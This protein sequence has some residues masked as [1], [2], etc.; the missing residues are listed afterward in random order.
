MS[1][2]EA[3]LR[4][5][6]VIVVVRLTSSLVAG[7]GCGLGL[8]AGAGAGLARVV[9]ISPIRALVDVTLAATVGY[10]AYQ[11]AYSTTHF[12]LWSSP[13]FGF[14]IIVG[15]PWSLLPAIV[16]FSVFVACSL[17]GF[18]KG[19]SLPPAPA[20]KQPLRLRRT[21]VGSSI[22][23]YRRSVG[24]WMRSEMHAA[25]VLIRSSAF[26]ALA[27]KLSGEETAALIGQSSPVW[28]AAIPVDEALNDMDD[29]T[30]DLGREGT[31]PDTTLSFL[32]LLAPGRLRLVSRS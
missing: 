13:L 6:L 32:V 12:I 22:F 10:V 3:L 20:G 25:V 19:R 2:L 11:T 28:L 5:Y 31:L 7:A 9:E 23:T 29:A 16:W 24:D 26:G 8:V 21:I 17:L 27:D 18:R 14:R 1:L 30:G 15:I 4:L